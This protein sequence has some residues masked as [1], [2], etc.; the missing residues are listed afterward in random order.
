MPKKP[1][2]LEKEE[3]NIRLP[4][5]IIDEIRRAATK[6][7]RPLS[8]EIRWRLAQSILHDFRHAKDAE[9]KS[10]HAQI[11]ELSRRVRRHYGADWHAD[12]GARHAFVRAVSL[13]LGALPVPAAKAEMQY[14]PAI[15][16]DVI[17]RGYAAE[18]KE[19]KEGKP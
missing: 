18:I 14:D 7:Q 1:P 8:K 11:T 6:T 3:L 5:T 16:G 12:E 9:L 2:G 4:V 10:L 13:W 19:Q 15:V 17:F